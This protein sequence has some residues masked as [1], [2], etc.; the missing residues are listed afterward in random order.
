[1]GDAKVGVSVGVDAGDVCKAIVD[2]GDDL[3]KKEWEMKC[4]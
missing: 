1:M 3:M 4:W 2:A